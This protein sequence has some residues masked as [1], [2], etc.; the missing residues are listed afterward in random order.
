MQIQIT[1]RHSELTP[2]VKELVERKFG[3]LERFVQKPADV[4]LVVSQEK[5]RYVAEVAL[6][7]GRTN[8]RGKAESHDLHLSLDQA[9][10]K[11]ERQLR[12]IMAKVKSPKTKGRTG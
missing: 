3:K 12:K 5:R 8:L 7:A 9:V 1:M 11:L 2:E 4:H 10:D 6:T